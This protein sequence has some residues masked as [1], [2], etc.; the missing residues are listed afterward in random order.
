MSIWELISLTL[1]ST[2]TIDIGV[3]DTPPDCVVCS[4][5]NEIWIQSSQTGDQPYSDTSPTV[6]AVSLTVILCLCYHLLAENLLKSWTFNTHKTTDFEWIVKA[7]QLSGHNIGSRLLGSTVR[8]PGKANSFRQTSLNKI[9]SSF[10]FLKHCC[11][12]KHSQRG[13]I[14]LK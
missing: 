2:K 11:L 8:Q 12:Q 1:K 10:T 13:S 3:G 7:R 5:A 6:G 14:A 9:K 4:K